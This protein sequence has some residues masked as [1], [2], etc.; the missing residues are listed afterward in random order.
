[1][2]EVE[3]EME[4]ETEAEVEACSGS[5]GAAD[6]GGYQWQQLW[7]VLHRDNKDNGRAEKLLQIF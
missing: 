5:S 6:I 4:E 2:A 1:M 7:P 3:V